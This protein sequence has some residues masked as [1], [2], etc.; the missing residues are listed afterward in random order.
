[1]LAISGG[2]DAVA[3]AAGLLSG[4]STYGTRPKFKLVTGISAGALIAPFAYLG[5]AYDDLIRTVAT[6]VGPDDFFDRRNVLIGLASDGM[7]D[8]G[9]LARLVAKYVTSETLAAI[10]TEYSKGRS[11]QVATTDLDSGRPVIWSMGAIAASDAPGALEL[12]RKI[13]V[14]SVL[15]PGVVSPVLF[16]VEIE[17]QR[18][19]ELHVDGGVI[20]QTYAYPRD[21]LQE[22]QRATG[23][24]Y[25]RAI[26][27]YVI[28]L[29]IPGDSARHF[30]H[31]LERGAG[32]FASS[33]AAA[34]TP[35]HQE[36]A[37]LL[38]PPRRG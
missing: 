19:Q 13:M 9:P 5:P 34:Y 8:S 29:K 37:F 27:D 33:Q 20:A 25:Q 2:G 31:A 3:F 23:Q 22:W 1:V 18:Y 12:F 30:T 10:A 36:M 28:P 4:W 38:E 14:A 11:L 26:H 24:P 7:A 21:S 16:D 6:S 17:G 32:A 15:I 35:H